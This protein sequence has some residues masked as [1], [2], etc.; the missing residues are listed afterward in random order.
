MQHRK[1]GCHGF[2]LNKLPFSSRNI[3]M[4]LCLIYTI[5]SCVTQKKIEARQREEAQA[6]I[7]SLGRPKENLSS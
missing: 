3:Q 5:Q 6:F 2:V 4:S 1:K 7:F